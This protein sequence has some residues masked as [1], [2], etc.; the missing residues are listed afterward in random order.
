MKTA[1]V[2]DLRN[3]FGEISNWIIQG[4]EITITKRGKPFA[5]IRSANRPKAPIKVLDRLKRLKELNPE[6]RISSD[7]TEEIRKDRDSRLC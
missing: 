1:T 4:E 5:T 6:G 7:S 3:R 2:A